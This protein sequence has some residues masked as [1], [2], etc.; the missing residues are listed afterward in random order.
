MERI[1]PLVD[2][3]DGQWFPLAGGHFTR[4]AEGQ[5][6][7]SRGEDVDGGQDGH[8]DGADKLTGGG[9]EDEGGEGNGVVQ[10]RQTEGDIGADTAGLGIVHAQSQHD[11]G[12]HLE[13]EAHVIQGIQQ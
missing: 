9:K 5:I 10:S 11:Q 6:G 4:A 1:Y 3:A 8:E 7:H 2:L 13:K 12:G